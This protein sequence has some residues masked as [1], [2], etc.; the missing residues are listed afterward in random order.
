MFI[1]CFDVIVRWFAAFW[2]IRQQWSAR[3]VADVENLGP[4]VL[5][6]VF[7]LSTSSRTASMDLYWSS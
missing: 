2:R 5:K 6:W 3:M 4:C 7:I 1:S